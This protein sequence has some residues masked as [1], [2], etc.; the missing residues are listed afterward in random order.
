[1]ITVVNKYTHKST[2]ND[3]YIGRGSILGN[4]YTHANLNTTKAKFKCD[5]RESA[6]TKYEEYILNEIK[7]DNLIIMNEL[8]RILDL[9]KY[10]N[11][12]LVCFCA[13]KGCHGNVIKNILEQMT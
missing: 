12:N 6:I 4:P 13:P 8:I 11:I 7:Y 5:S 3:I 10:K 9:S 1:M 2:S